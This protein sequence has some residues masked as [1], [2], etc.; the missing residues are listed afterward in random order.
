MTDEE[1]L[2]LIK[3]LR[4]AEEVITRL[5]E[6]TG[7]TDPAHGMLAVVEATEALEA[8]NARLRESLE[9]AAAVFDGYAVHHDRRAETWPAGNDAHEASKSKAKENRGHARALRRAL[10]KRDAP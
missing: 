10:E 5:A 7:I 4:H 8:E 9:A 6:K 3:R 2:A 1:T